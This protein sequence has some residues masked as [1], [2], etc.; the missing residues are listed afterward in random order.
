MKLRTNLN[1]LWLVLVLAGLLLSACS[2]GEQTPTVEPVSQEE[3][4]PVVSATGVVVPREWITLSMSTNGNVAEVLVAENDQV[5]AG[6]ALVRL[7]GEEH[8]QAAIEARR[9]ELA[10]AKHDLDQMYDDPEIQVAQAYQAVVDARIERRDAQRRLDNLHVATP[11]RDIEQSRANVAI[12]KDRMERVRKDYRPYENKPEDNLIRAGLLSKLAQI[13]KQYE[14]AVRKLNNQLGT[15][16]ELDLAEAEADFQLAEAKLQTAERDYEIKK[17]GLDPED[18]ALAEARIDNAQVQLTAAEAALEDLDLLSPIAG[19]VTELSAKPGEWIAPG[20]P[21]LQLADLSKLHI[22]TTDL[23]E[24]DVA[25]VDVGDAALVTFDSLPGVVLNGK[26]V[27]IAPKAS[28]GAGVNYT[29][30]IEL[31]EVP[32]ALRWGMTA[33]V[34]IEVEP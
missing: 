33:F 22:E 11:S 17:A 15:V 29:V 30:W 13:E 28:T 31:E 5:S 27:R 21:L 7:Q 8:L 2:A 25:R 26:V 14:A 12:L 23:N 32:E 16:N 10:S 4:K 3:V 20:Q 24:I 19:T 18:L 1:K 6:D 34:D 9:F